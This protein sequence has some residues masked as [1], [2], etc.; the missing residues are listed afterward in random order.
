MSGWSSDMVVG[1][2]ILGLLARAAEERNPDEGFFATR[3]TADLF[4]P[5]RMARIDTNSHVV[6]W[7]HRIRVVDSALLQDGVVVA[8]A[9]V[10]FYRKANNAEGER[11]ASPDTPKPPPAET[12]PGE[13]MIGISEPSHGWMP[14]SRTDT[15]LHTAT[16]KRIWA[17]NWAAVED[18]TATP[19]VRAAMVSDLTNLVT[20]LGTAGIG[21]INGDVTLTLARTP[22]GPDLGL[23]ADNH[24]DSNGIAV[25]S[26]TLFD[27]QGR[28]GTCLV[29]AIEQ[30]DHVSLPQ[31]G[32]AVSAESCP[33]R[34][35][36]PPNIGGV[37]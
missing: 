26:A 4:R 27:R 35:A 30:A 6:R 21:Y 16:R 18:E 33:A 5:V 2:A 10:I 29:T 17:R 9:S 11:W 36:I 25:G 8:R 34:T 22:E 20:N 37:R 24:L 31:V 3:L 32:R 28:L 23:E 14:W 1:P 15:A 7:G 12:L 19:F 13:R